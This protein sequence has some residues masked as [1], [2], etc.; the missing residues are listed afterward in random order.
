[1]K[2]RNVTEKYIIISYIRYIV[3]STAD[4]HTQSSRVCLEQKR[5]LSFYIKYSNITWALL[6]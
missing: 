6:T 3:I 1:M 5:V 4:R 2:N